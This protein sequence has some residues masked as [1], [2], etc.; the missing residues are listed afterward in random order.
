[1]SLKLWT[2][3]SF[4]FLIAVICYTMVQLVYTIIYLISPKSMIIEIMENSVSV[5]RFVLLFVPVIIFTL[6]FGLQNSKKFFFDFW[7]KYWLYYLFYIVILYLTR[8]NIVLGYY[9]IDFTIIGL[10]FELSENAV[11]DFLMAYIYT[12]FDSSTAILF[13][14]LLPHYFLIFTRPYLKNQK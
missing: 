12:L 7:R 8:K 3:S 10:Y 14:I 4:V 6:H 9:S 13:F 11:S 2:K 1:M 5:L